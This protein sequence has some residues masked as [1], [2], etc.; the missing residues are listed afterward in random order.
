[1]IR[2]IFDANHQTYGYRRIHAVLVRSGEQA[3]PELVRDLMRELRLIPCQP[4][5]WRPVTT[6][7]STHRIPDLLRRDF[8]ADRP[9]R[10]HGGFPYSYTS[11]HSM[12][13]RRQR[14]SVGY[15]GVSAPVADSDTPIG[16]SVP[17]D[18]TVIVPDGWFQLK[19]DPE[20]RDQGIAYTLSSAPFEELPPGFLFHPIRRVLQGGGPTS[21]RIH[22]GSPRARCRSVRCLSRPS[23]PPRAFGP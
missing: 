9:A 18:Y 15:R 23:H 5:P 2:E 19:L 16:E 11:P 8:T 17:S 7:A 4:R 1:M 3:S 12:R 6:Q 10:S 21:R 22:A 14:N 20:V 13:R